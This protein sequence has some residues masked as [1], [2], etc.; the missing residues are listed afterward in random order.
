MMIN[1]AML[2]GK[3]G[4]SLRIVTQIGRLNSLTSKHMPGSRMFC[5][6][7][8]Q[9]PLGRGGLVFHLCAARFR[10]PFGHPQRRP[11]V[12]HRILS[13]SNSSRARSHEQFVKYTTISLAKMIISEHIE[14]MTTNRGNPGAPISRLAS[15]PAPPEP[16]WI[17]ILSK[18]LWR[19]AVPGLALLNHIQSMQFR[20][21]FVYSNHPNP[22]YS[23]LFRGY[24]ASCSRQNSPDPLRSLR[25]IFAAASPPRRPFPI[26]PKSG[27]IK[28][29]PGKS[30]QIKPNG[31]SFSFKIRRLLLCIPDLIFFQPA[32]TVGSF[33]V[34]DR[35]Q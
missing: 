31:P 32:R 23:G 16:N 33:H 10:F 4:I 8:Q 20:S 29:N 6:P 18:P 3:I 5:T 11:G 2:A 35:I 19:L 17:S 24:P 14:N 26:N 7:L 15:S 22:A 30:N 21:L 25:F 27:L 28:P 12:E 13:L 34:P 9:R 1:K